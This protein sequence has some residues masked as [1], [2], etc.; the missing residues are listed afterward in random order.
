MIILLKIVEILLKW[1][2]VSLIAT[3]KVLLVVS[4]KGL[5]GML[6]PRCVPHVWIEIPIIIHC[7]SIIYSCPQVGN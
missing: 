5:H 3:E 6:L 4:N 1:I 2:E 7:D